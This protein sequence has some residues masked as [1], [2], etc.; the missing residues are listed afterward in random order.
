MSSDTFSYSC[1]CREILAFCSTIASFSTTSGRFPSVLALTVSRASFASRPRRTSGI[2]LLAGAVLPSCHSTYHPPVRIA[3]S[4]FPI[5]P[6]WWDKLLKVILRQQK[7]EQESLLQDP[8]HS[9][10]QGWVPECELLSLHD[11]TDF[12]SQLQT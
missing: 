5:M 1:S 2:L 6:S 11:M 4:I 12:V 8:V 3:V 7:R 9:H 10:L